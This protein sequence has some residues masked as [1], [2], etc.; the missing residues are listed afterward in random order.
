MP[1]GRPHTDTVPAGDRPPH[2]Q[3]TSPLSFNRKLV[4]QEIVAKLTDLKA[5]I[6]RG[7]LNLAVSRPSGSVGIC[8]SRS[9]LS[10]TVWLRFH[11]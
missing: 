3:C 2:D 7:E 6:E 11:R 5:A 9:S 4:Q 1:R 8:T 10:I